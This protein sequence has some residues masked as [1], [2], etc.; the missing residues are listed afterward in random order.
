VIARSI[1]R[2]YTERAS[3]GFSYA[4]IAVLFRVNSQSLPLQIALIREEIP[5][6]CRR[7][8]NVIVSDTMERLL[9]LVQLYLRLRQDPTY[10]SRNETRLL[11]DCY[12]RF[13]TAGEVSSL[14][15]AASD[16][17][18]YVAGA[19]HLAFSGANQK[20]TSDF[21]RAVECL[22]GEK[23][24]GQLIMDVATHF[25]NLGGLIGT[26]EDA[27]EGNLPLG[28][29]I[30][31]SSRFRGDT[32]QFHEML[33]GLLGRV[34][35]GLFREVEGDAV[36]LLTYFRAKGRQW[37]T[38]FL[39][40]V[41]GKVIPHGRAAENVDDERRLFYV[42][43]TRP[44]ANLILS[45]VRHAVRTKVEPSPFLLELGLTEAEEKRAGSIA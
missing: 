38:V 28:E 36:N 15:T 17:G 21:V 18:G 19:R 13:V 12:F 42:A 11:C 44:T 14:G 6:H 43:V 23:S 40:G 37:H 26:L 5:Y 32:K 24:P 3:K 45:Y 34:Q 41:N 7:E 31:I 1:K 8:D 30:D 16:R 25:K 35:G 2:L 20:F 39:P 22:T 9:G 27:I 4:D 10:T 33:S 29:L